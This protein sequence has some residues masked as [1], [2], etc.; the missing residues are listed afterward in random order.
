MA[1]ITDPQAVKFCNEQIRA[2]ADV[3]AQ[4]YYRAKILKNIYDSQGISALI[5]N[6][7]DIVVDGSAQDGRAPI[8][9]AKVT[10]F[11]NALTNLITDLEANSNAKLNVLLQIAVNPNRI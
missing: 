11:T 7:A 3:Y 1:A 6:T 8:T 10:G 9:G 2:M 4:M 5:P